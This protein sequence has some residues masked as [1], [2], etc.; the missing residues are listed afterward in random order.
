VSSTPVLYGV[1]M[2]YQLLELQAIYRHPRKIY[3]VADNIAR[4]N[5]THTA[6][7]T[8]SAKQQAANTQLKGP[9]A[10]SGNARD[11]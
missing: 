11:G 2:N 10:K 3:E 8:A 5:A 6:N 4:Q 1:G 7:P 9:N